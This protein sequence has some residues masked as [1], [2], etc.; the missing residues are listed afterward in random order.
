MRRDGGFTLLELMVA[1]ALMATVTALAFG[2][3]RTGARVWERREAAALTDGAVAQR[4][5][6]LLE[7]AVLR[8]VPGPKLSRLAPFAGRPDGFDLLRAEEGGLNAWRA[9]F[10]AEAGGTRLTLWRRAVARPDAILPA[11]GLPGLDWGLPLVSFPGLPP[12]SLAYA[13]RDGPFSAEWSG[14]PVAPALVRLR[15]GARETVLRPGGRQ[16]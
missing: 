7:G 14:R 13:G 5:G 1:L 16:W 15:I 4:I 2:S 10:V 11:P 12:V 3:L 8:P 6:A 9:R